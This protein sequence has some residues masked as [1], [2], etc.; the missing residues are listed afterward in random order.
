ME[1]RIKEPENE[2][3][4]LRVNIYHYM[5]YRRDKFKKEYGLTDYEYIKLQDKVKD[6]VIL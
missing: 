1:Y 2:V 3:R 4:K 5:T 6:A